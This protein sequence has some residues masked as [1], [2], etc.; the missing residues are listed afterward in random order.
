M[1]FFYSHRLPIAEA[2]K[3]K[4]YDVVIGYGESG[5]VDPK[6]LERKG[7]KI[8]LVPME[9]GS[10]NIFKEI[11]VIFNILIFLIREK[12]DILHLITVKPY[13][14]G[15]IISRLIKVPILVTAISGLG[16]LFIH[17]NLRSRLLRF[18]LFP[19]YKFALNHSNQNVILQNISDAETLNNWG[20]LNSKKIRI[21]KGSGINLN[22]FTNLQEINNIP[23]ICFAGR[24]LKDKGV[25]EFVSAAKI[26]RDRGVH[27]IFYLAG[28]LDY[29]NPSSINQKYLNELKKEKNIKVLGFQNN[30]PKLYSKSHIVCLPSYRE[31]LPKALMEA[32][33]AGRAVVTTDVPGCR[34]AIIPNKTGLLVPIK[35]SNKLADALQ[36]LI[37]HPHERIAMGKAGRQLAEKEFQIEKITRNHFDIYEDLISKIQ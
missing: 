37:E 6:L 17:N 13:L 18:F 20:V 34:D 8:N 30:I 2:A 12:P 29:S 19:M 33:A 25:H 26:I 14:Y 21:I 5:R 7:F 28:D 9:R 16:T 10:I 15:G 35:N 36:W 32:A 27:A 11:K 3:D 1:S 31:G 4:G 23:A 22:D 24:L